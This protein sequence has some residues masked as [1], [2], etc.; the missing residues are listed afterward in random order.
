MTPLIGDTANWPGV[1]KVAAA[2]VIAVATIRLQ[3][4]EGTEQP[5]MRHGV[6]HTE[7][8]MKQATF[9]AAAALTL[10]LGNAA[11]AESN[12]LASVESPQT[13]SVVQG[14]GT[15]AGGGSEAYPA[16]AAAQSVPVSAGADLLLPANGSEGVLQTAASLPR[17]FSEGTV[18]YAQAQ[19]VA[20]FFAERERR[21]RFATQP[22]T[23][24]HPG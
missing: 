8:S 4:I 23:K 15:A 19:S 22:Q 10:I 20:R 5:P 17:G 14:G 6:F 7:A 11:M 12:N 9:A 2:S 24:A 13:P 16:F 21:A 18:A 1:N 3:A